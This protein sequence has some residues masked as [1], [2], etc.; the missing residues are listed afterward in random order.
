MTNGPVMEF[1]NLEFRYPDLLTA[2]DAPPVLAH[3]RG[4][5]I[6]TGFPLFFD[7][8]EVRQSSQRRKFSSSGAVSGVN[9]WP[10]SRQRITAGY[11]HPSPKHPSGGHPATP[12]SAARGCSARLFML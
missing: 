8:E 7:A 4:S 2:V 3:S 9:L 6:V 12:R 5:D 11:S 1:R 10:Q